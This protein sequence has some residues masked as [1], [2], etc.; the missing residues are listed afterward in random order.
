M[1]SKTPDTKLAGLQ[2]LRAIA[3]IMVLV[4]HVIAEAEHYFDLSLPGDAI[5]WTRGVDIFFVISGFVITLSIARH[6]KQPSAFLKRRLWRVVPLYWFFTTLMV[7]SLLLIDGGAKD[8]VFD[9]RQILSSY[10]FFP[11]ERLDGRIAPVLSLGWTLNYE[12]FFYVIAAACL[13]FRRPLAATALAL[14]GLVIA[15]ALH[16]APGTALL[17]WSNPIVLEFLFG[18][19]LAKVWQTGV[20]KPSQKGALLLAIVSFA[21]LVMLDDTTLPRFIAAG[22]PAAGL[23]A[24]GTLFF[25]NVT[26]A[27]LIWGDASYAL[28]LSH[29][30]VLRGATLVFLPLLPPTSLGAWVYVVAVCV[31]SLGIGLLTHLWIERPFLKGWPIRKSM[32]LT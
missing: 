11:Y 7:L 6:I 5:P 4:G 1:R 32:V 17:F 10:V 27:G 30:F 31:M 20:Y 22:L 9:M 2:A 18:V 14:I 21:L 23:V 19:A 13:G 24:A 3:A 8:T 15:G 28:Y 25:P 12:V 26:F 29:R 16:P